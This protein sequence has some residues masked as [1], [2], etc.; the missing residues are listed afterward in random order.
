MRVVGRNGQRQGRPIRIICSSVCAR[1]I[2]NRLSGIGRERE[3]RRF[4]NR[5]WIL[6]HLK[7][8]HEEL[9]R[10]IEEFEKRSDY[11]VG[12]Y[13]VAM[14][15]LYHHLNTAWNSKDVSDEDARTSSDESFSKW[16]QFPSDIDMSVD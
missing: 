6:F 9:R 5:K 11:D 13:F 12:E 15:H 7:E 14:M 4:M 16:R 2:R 8:A 1:S 10:T 3:N